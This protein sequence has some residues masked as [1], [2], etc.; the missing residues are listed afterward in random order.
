M[1][2]SRLLI[3]EYECVCVKHLSM[4]KNV[5]TVKLKVPGG[6]HSQQT[7]TAWP[8]LGIIAFTGGYFSSVDFEMGV[9]NRLQEVSANRRLKT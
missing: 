8:F 9:C 5:I 2:Q 1:W 6:L 7:L 3:T 4:H